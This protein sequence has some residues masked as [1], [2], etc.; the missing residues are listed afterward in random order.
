MLSVI[1][2]D[3]NDRYDFTDHAFFQLKRQTRLPDQVI[4]VDYI[5]ISTR[6]DLSERLQTG[7]KECLGDKVVI[8]E[9]DDYY[10]DDY[11]ERV[12]EKLNDFQ[13]VGFDFTIYYHLRFLTYNFLSHFSPPRASLAFTSFQKDAIT[14]FKFPGNQN[15][16]IDMELWKWANAL[17]MFLFSPQDCEKD[18]FVPVSIKHGVGLC[19]VRWH[20]Q[21]MNGAVHDQRMEWLKERTRK[22]SFDFYSKWHT[23]H[24]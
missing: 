13:I 12:D 11:L 21:M 17:K 9:N 2:P 7:L 3:R 20:Y 22:E 6:Y 23:N 16:L 19:G 14:G 8:W 4:H 24:R 18:K 5:P 10:P 1:I 15:P